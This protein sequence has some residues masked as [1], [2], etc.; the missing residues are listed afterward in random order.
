VSISQSTF[1]EPFC[2]MA[3]DHDHSGHA[4]SKEGHIDVF[5]QQGM[6]CAPLYNMKQQKNVGS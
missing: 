2:G 6:R 5:Y 1:L 4:R 3:I